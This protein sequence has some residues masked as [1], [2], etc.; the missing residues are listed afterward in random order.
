MEDTGPNLLIPAIIAFSLL[1]VG[2]ALTIHEFITRRNIGR[3]PVDHT[4]KLVKPGP[5]Q[6]SVPGNADG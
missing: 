5:Q 3:D 6:R 4:V 2:L 1:L